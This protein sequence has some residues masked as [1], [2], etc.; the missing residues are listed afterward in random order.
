MV[1]GR[2]MVLARLLQL[3]KSTQGNLRYK[4][5]KSITTYILIFD[6][7]RYIIPVIFAIVTFNLKGE[8]KGTNVSLGA[9]KPAFTPST[10]THS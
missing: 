8:D 3:G 1:L 7:L 4:I 9:N 2:A 5:R 6:F 10:F